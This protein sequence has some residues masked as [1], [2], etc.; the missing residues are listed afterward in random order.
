MRPRQTC[1][2]TSSASTIRNA[3]TPGSVR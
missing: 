2:I 1:S 3:G